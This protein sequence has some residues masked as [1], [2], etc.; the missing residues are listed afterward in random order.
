V[1]IRL[2]D[3]PAIETVNLRYRAGWTSHGRSDA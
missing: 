2:P 3:G 1:L